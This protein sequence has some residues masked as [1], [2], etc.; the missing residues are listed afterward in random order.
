MLNVS[1]RGAGRRKKSRICCARHQTAIVV[2][3]LGCHTRLATAERSIIHV[4][5]S[6]C[7]HGGVV[8][9]VG[10]FRVAAM[11]FGFCQERK[12]VLKIG[13]KLMSVENYVG[14]KSKIDDFNFTYSHWAGTRT[15]FEAEIAYPDPSPIPSASSHKSPEIRQ[16]QLVVAVDGLRWKIASVEC[17]RTD[18]SARHARKSPKLSSNTTKCRIWGFVCMLIGFYSIRLLSMAHRCRSVRWAIRDRLVLQ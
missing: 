10:N 1:L 13:E 18:S 15:W 5:L 6:I 17:R 2:V 4:N 7:P 8:V 14:I 12:K 3:R 11:E 16:F 9:I